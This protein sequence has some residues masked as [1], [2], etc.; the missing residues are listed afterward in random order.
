[1]ILVQRRPQV[2]SVRLWEKCAHA[3]SHLGR[4]SAYFPPSTEHPATSLHL[5]ALVLILP[6]LGT[7]RPALPTVES[8]RIPSSNVIAPVRPADGGEI[9]VPVEFDRAPSQLAAP[10]Q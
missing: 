6:L 10:R 3:P 1:M 9:A 7:Y 8:R 2:A 4:S 5:F